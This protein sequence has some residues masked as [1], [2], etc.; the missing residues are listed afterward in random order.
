[1][2]TNKQ[3]FTLVELIVVI[4]ILAI[5]WTIAFLAFQWYSK[6]SRDSV[7]ISDLSNIEKALELQ[8]TKAWRVFVP[9][10]NVEITASGTVIS[11]QWYAWEKTLS[12]LWVHGWWKDP[13]D[14]TYY[15]YM[16]NANYTRY[17]LM[18]FLEDWGVAWYFNEVNAVDLTNRFP[19]TKWSQLWIVLDPTTNALLQETWTWVDV[20]NTVD[21]FDVYL[22]N[23][24]K[25]TW[26]WAEMKKLESLVLYWTAN[27]CK[28]LLEKNKQLK[29]VDWIYTI[30]PTW[31]S[32]FEVYC[33]MVTDWWGWTMLAYAEWES[34]V[35]Y[36]H[37][38]IINWIPKNSENCWL[39]T[40]CISKSWLSINSWDSLMIYTRWYKVKWIWCNDKWLSIK[41]YSDL[42]F[43]AYNNNKN[44]DDIDKWAQGSC[45]KLSELTVWETV[46]E[47]SSQADT[48]WQIRMWIKHKWNDKNES[49]L[50]FFGPT[51]MPIWLWNIRD[52]YPNSKINHHYSSDMQYQYNLWDWASIEKQTWFIR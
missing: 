11:Y 42:P 49:S 28:D 17:Q 2:K 35:T 33:D 34:T 46:S 8:L 1:M 40:E 20:V 15:T 5:L 50:L 24:E 32:N 9:E 18:W 22:D 4:T 43:L 51:F 44:W 7:R 25:I 23:S 39:N 10:N 13:V 37:D 45:D 41:G 30:N 29:D 52:D 36:N 47:L 6:D 31:S 3:A 21:T 12:N 16:T 48:W 14:D 26:T 38:D 27:S 19:I